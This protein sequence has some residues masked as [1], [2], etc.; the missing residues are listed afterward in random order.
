MK[1]FKLKFIPWR[2]K[3]F[4]KTIEKVRKK[5]FPEIK[6]RIWTMQIPFPIPGAA[7]FYILPWIKLILFTNKCKELTDKVLVGL[8]AHELS[9]FSRFDSKG[10][11]FYYWKY[12]FFVWGEK[13]K[14]EERETDKLTLRKGYSKELLELKVEAE[15]RLKGTKWEKY[16]DNYL[17]GSESKAYV[18]KINKS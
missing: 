10:G 13:G 14:I 17:T 6:G 4:R 1:L 12:F 18:K 11:F 8:I 15:K 3:R 7:V 2:M 9:H 16:L 5:S